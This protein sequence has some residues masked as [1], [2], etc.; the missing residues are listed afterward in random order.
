MGYWWLEW[1]LDDLK[2]YFRIE[3]AKSCEIDDCTIH[4]NL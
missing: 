2:V 4:N 1:L 3:I